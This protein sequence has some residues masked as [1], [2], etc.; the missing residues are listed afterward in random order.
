MYWLRVDRSSVLLF[1]IMKRTKE[2]K[3]KEE[4]EPR[5]RCGGRPGV[6]VVCVGGIGVGV[7]VVSSLL[8]GGVGLKLRE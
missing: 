8:F 1:V 7:G 5:G 3:R 6:V 2:K 4:T